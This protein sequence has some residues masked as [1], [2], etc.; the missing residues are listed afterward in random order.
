MSR[1]RRARV[2]SLSASCSSIYRER[3]SESRKLYLTLE[4]TDSDALWAKPKIF[5]AFLVS[6]GNTEAAPHEHNERHCN[7]RSLSMKS[8]AKNPYQRV[9]MY[10]RTQLRDLSI[11]IPSSA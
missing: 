2:K 10:R 4:L 6:R 1:P 9:K 11:H 7:A 8:I 5:G 3:D